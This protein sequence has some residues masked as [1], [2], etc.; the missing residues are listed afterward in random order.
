MNQ[1]SDGYEGRMERKAKEKMDGLCSEL[2]ML[3]KEVD[4]AMT[5]NRGEWKKMACCADPK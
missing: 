2:T 1:K 4:D 3:E 5:A